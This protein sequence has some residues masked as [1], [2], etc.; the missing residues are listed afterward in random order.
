MD[1]RV[2]TTLRPIRLNRGG[3]GPLSPSPYTPNRMARNLQVSRYYSL[4]IVE[5]DIMFRRY[6]P[7]PKG[8]IAP[9]WTCW[10]AEHEAWFGVDAAISAHLEDHYAGAEILRGS[11]LAELAF[12]AERF[13]MRWREEA[14]KAFAPVVAEVEGIGQRINAQLEVIRS[15]PWFPQQAAML[16]DLQSLWELIEDLPLACRRFQELYPAGAEEEPA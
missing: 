2:E 7:E 15:L 9:T 16:R 10:S 13:Q 5:D 8:A 11:E 14:I 1:T 12:E 4:I 6:A 3:L